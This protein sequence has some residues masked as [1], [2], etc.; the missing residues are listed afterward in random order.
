MTT[1]SAGTG[2]EDRTSVRR[3]TGKPNIPPAPLAGFIS[4]SRYVVILGV[5]TV[6]VISAVLLFLGI[7]MTVMRL[8]VVVPSTITGQMTA[9]EVT[10]EFLEIVTVMLKAIFFYIIGVGSYSLFVAPLNLP[11]AL[12]VETLNDLENKVVSIIIVIMAVSYLEHFI[13]WQNP[14]EL[15]QNGVAL[16]LVSA[17]LIGFQ[18]VSHY[19]KEKA[20]A[21]ENRVQQNAHDE[22]FQDHRERNEARLKES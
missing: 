6:L 5:L 1:P 11:I 10:V 3:S 8:W 2:L 7:V 14:M 9:S 13:A 4:H 16:A 19:T 22:L 12:G 21:S 17:G 20:S 15:L 18:F